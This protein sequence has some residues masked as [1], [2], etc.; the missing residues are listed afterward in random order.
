M[1]CQNKKIKFLKINLKIQYKN[2][3][4]FDK[5]IFKK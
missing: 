2:I 3:I 1:Y 4:I 5:N